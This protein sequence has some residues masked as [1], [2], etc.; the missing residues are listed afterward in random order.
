MISVSAAGSVLTF[1][2]LSRRSLMLLI[3]LV[4]KNGFKL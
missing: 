4:M 2:L 3:M 1:V